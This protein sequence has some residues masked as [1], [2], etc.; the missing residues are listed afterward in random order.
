MVLAVQL[1][2]VYRESILGFVSKKAL[3]GKR[4]ALVNPT[5]VSTW[6]SVLPGFAPAAELVAWRVPKGAT[7]VVEQ[8]APKPLTPRLVSLERMDASLRRADQLAPLKQ[9]PPADESVPPLG[10]T[11]GVGPWEPN[12]S[13]THKKERGSI[14]FV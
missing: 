8:K 12:I 4:I 9:G 7:F 14:Y 13:V 3:G 1:Y 10:Q 11:A 2:D 5:L 6:F